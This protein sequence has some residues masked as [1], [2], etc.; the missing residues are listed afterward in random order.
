MTEETR[1]PFPNEPSQSDWEEN[2][3]EWEEAANNLQRQYPAA[4]VFETKVLYTFGMMR[5][6]L[7]SSGWTLE[8]NAPFYFPAYLLACGA[9]ELMGHCVMEEFEETRYQRR[10]RRGLERMI[11]VCPHCGKSN[12][13]GEYSDDSWKTD[14]EHVI[15]LAAG[16]TYTI[17]DCKRFR[18]FMAHGM[19]DP[20][21]R[22][23][24]T[25]EFVG[26]FICRVCQGIDRYY[27]ALCADTPGGEELRERF[28]KAAVLPI[29]DNDGL[30]HASH[31]YEPLIH[32]PFATPCGALLH[33]SMWRAYCS[34]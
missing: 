11:E 23:R 33:E 14:D 16:H 24:F 21:G 18:N 12:I 27:Q 1:R 15:V 29:W 32:P 4:T 19:A 22:L 8:H 3:D 7:E 10:L 31:L 28:V 6:L 34:E 30:I 26:R 13:R 17:G 25:P 9:V 20:G 2:W 5:H